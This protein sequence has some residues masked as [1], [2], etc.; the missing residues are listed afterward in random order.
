MLPNDNIQFVQQEKREKTEL[1]KPLSISCITFLKFVMRSRI[2]SNTCTYNNCVVRIEPNLWKISPTSSRERRPKPLVFFLISFYV[3]DRS[4]FD[5][6][7]NESRRGR[8]WERLSKEFAKKRKK[9]QYRNSERK[10]TEYKIIR[11]R[12]RS[13]KF[14][15]GY[16]EKSSLRNV[17][18]FRDTYLIARTF[19]WIDFSICVLQ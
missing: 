14:L 3:D 2:V 9:L 6:R 4:I 7:S 11:G 18:S 15:H 8:R 13:V 16:F 10:A 19:A 17:I 1:P 12:F 5:D